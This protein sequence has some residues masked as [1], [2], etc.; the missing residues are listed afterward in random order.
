MTERCLN[1]N[2]SCKGT[3]ANARKSFLHKRILAM[4]LTDAQYTMRTIPSCKWTCCSMVCNRS[5]NSLFSA[6]RPLV[7]LCEWQ[8][9]FWWIFCTS[10]RICHIHMSTRKRYAGVQDDELYH[11]W[12]KNLKHCPNHL[13]CYIFEKWQQKIKLSFYASSHK[14]GIV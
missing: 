10:H 3:N 4:K 12:P 6:V 5:F 2:K 9:Y 8:N 1:L 7:S 14:H 11:N 13:I